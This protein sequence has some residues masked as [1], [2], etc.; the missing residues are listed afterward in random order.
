MLVM[1]RKIGEAIDIGDEIKIVVL[2]VNGSR[3]KL[4]FSG[5]RDITIRRAELPD[6]REF[7]ESAPAVQSKPVVA[8]LGDEPARAAAAPLRAFRASKRRA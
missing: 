4:G 7:A 2:E 5:P 8:F 3:V 6:P 1:T